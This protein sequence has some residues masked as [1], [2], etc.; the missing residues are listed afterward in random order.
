MR[1]LEPGRGRRDARSSRTLLWA[2]AFVL[3][4]AIVSSLLVKA[5]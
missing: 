5:L 4:V 3:A 2:A 1:Y